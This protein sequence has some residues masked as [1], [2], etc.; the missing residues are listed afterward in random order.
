MHMDPW[1]SGQAIVI[2]EHT[3]NRNS[4][5]RNR[6]EQQQH[7]SNTGTGHRH[8]NRTEQQQHGSNT[9][10]DN[11]N[12]DRTKPSPEKEKTGPTRRDRTGEQRDQ[13]GRAERT[14]GRQEAENRGRRRSKEKTKKPETDQSRKTKGHHA[15]TPSKQPE[16]HPA[17]PQTRANTGGG[18]P[19]NPQPRPSEKRTNGA[20]KEGATPTP[21]TRAD[22]QARWTPGDTTQE[23]PAGAPAEG[24]AA[25]GGQ[26]RRGTGGQPHQPAE[27]TKVGTAAKGGGMYAVLL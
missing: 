1:E 25:K 6:T 3:L 11:N 2:R 13:A 24:A 20:K 15:P 16:A 27:T 21:A 19:K 17:N 8:R 5:H 4:R 22:H 18:H 9:G 26:R 23:G 12:R 10:P 14:P 7:G